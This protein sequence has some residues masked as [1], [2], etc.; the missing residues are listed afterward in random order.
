MVLGGGGGGGGGAG[1]AV[2]SVSAHQEILVIL[3]VTR[4]F[5]LARTFLH[6]V[7]C[8][9]ISAHTRVT[10]AGILKHFT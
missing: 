2:C 7:D 3:R 8:L 4:L 1:G 10:D 9:H 5:L 6:Y